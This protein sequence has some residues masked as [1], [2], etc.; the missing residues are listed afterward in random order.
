MLRELNLNKMEAVSGGMAVILM[1][2]TIKIVVMLL[3][4]ETLTL[5]KFDKVDQEG[6]A[7]V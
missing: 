7:Q 2:N 5:M 3:P 4:H 6:Q 1:V